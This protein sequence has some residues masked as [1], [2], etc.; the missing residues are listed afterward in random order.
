V[1]AR[2][3]KD[4][5][6]QAT[7]QK[8]AE[9]RVKT[10]HE[11]LKLRQRLINLLNEIPDDR[12]HLTFKYYFT[13][14]FI[15]LTE[16]IFNKENTLSNQIEIPWP[17]EKPASPKLVPRNEVIRRVSMA[18]SQTQVIELQRLYEEMKSFQSLPGRTVASS[19]LE[20][21]QR[22]VT[23]ER[24]KYISH[25]VEFSKLRIKSLIAHGKSEKELNEA[26]LNLIRKVNTVRLSPLKKESAIS[27]KHCVG[28]LPNAYYTPRDHSIGLCPSVYLLPDPG[29]LVLISHELTHSIAPCTSQFG[30]YEINSDALVKS[31][32]GLA[33]GLSREIMRDPNKREL[34]EH[35]LEINE[36]SNMTA[37]ALGLLSSE[38]AIKYFIDKKVL[39]PEIPGVKPDQ[40]PFK[41][42]VEC[43]ISKKGF[44]SFG[45][46]EIRNLASNVVKGRALYRE[47]GYD[48]K[49]DERQIVDAFMKF[50]GCVDMD[51]HGQLEEAFSDW[52]ASKVLG[53][54]LIGNRLDSDEEKLG[55]VAV[56]AGE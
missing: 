10:K 40:Y 14:N 47:V 34:V 52:V 53:D 4:E 39:K 36:K 7:L 42:V 44:R 43:L 5:K 22:R 25:L 37:S 9:N 23:P 56:L 20:E 45:E 1:L 17:M 27:G 24:E 30:T 11:F 15:E 51:N 18:L 33:G 46:S 49:L 6:F 19:L 12:M 16:A 8:R 3:L 26:E 13:E 38:E 32:Q 21:A 48:P 29:V 2:Q 35:L 41:Q 55:M 50:P 28:N 54:Y 31:G